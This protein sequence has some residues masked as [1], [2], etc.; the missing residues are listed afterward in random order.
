[1]AGGSTVIE[2]AT[3]SRMCTSGRLTLAIAAGDEA[4]QTTEQ[5]TAGTIANAR[6]DSNPPA[7]LA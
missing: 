7:R 4:P 2:A 1:M 6:A 5:S 3:I